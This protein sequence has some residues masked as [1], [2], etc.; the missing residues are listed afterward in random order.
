[1]R[2]SFLFGILWQNRKGLI[3]LALLSGTAFAQVATKPIDG[4]VDSASGNSALLNPIPVSPVIVA[5]ASTGPGAV[6]ASP[7]ANNALPEA[8]ESP[9]FWDNE[10]RARSRQWLRSALLTS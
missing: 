3:V 5:S 8:P 7:V 4:S 6:T 10:N 2:A 9:K 1:M